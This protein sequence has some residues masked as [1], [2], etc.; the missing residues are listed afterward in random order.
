MRITTIALAMA[1]SILS[2]P[3][4]VMAAPAKTQESLHRVDFRVEGASCVTCLRRIAKT[5]RDS[6]GVLKSDVS[7][8]KPYWSIVIYDAKTTNFQ[9]LA[10]P[11]IKAESVKFQEVEDKPIAELP[12]IV[13]PK[14]NTPPK[15]NAGGSGAPNAIG[16]TTHQTSK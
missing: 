5:L 9:K 1:V 6:K 13:I 4:P 10:E 12:L 3:T 14:L 15:P 16:A 2:L 8:Y 11:I 7:I